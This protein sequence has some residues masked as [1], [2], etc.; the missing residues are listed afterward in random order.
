MAQV[1]KPKPATGS[2]NFSDEVSTGSGSDLVRLVIGS[3]LLA[4]KT[5]S[6]PLPVLTPLRVRKLGHYAAT[7]CSEKGREAL[8]TGKLP[9][10]LVYWLRI[11]AVPGQLTL[12]LFLFGFLSFFSR[13]LLFVFVLHAHHFSS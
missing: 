12:V 3:T 5:R 1:S 9:S 4:T 2:P 11:I 7:G 13:F 8:S 10:D 6:L